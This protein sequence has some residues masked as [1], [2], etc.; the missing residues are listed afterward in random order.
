[1]S[2][3]IGAIN[4]SEESEERVK[5]MKKLYQ[6]G[7]KMIAGTDAGVPKTDFIQLPRSIK[8][9]ADYIGLTNY[10]A[11]KA[12]TSNAASALGIDKKVGTIEEGKI[13]DIIILDG[14]P[15]ENLD[16]L[17]KI[18]MIIKEGEIVFQDSCVKIK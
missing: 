4:L 5:T 1:M 15:L 3:S 13:A 10:E 11:I 2:S 9:L 12:G 8:L 16:N 14:D 7:V 17:Q 18:V 6:S